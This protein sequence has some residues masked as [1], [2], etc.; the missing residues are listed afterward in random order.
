M[1]YQT[2]TSRCVALYVRG[3]ARTTEDAAALVRRALRD[4][5]LAGWPRMELDLFPS[6]GGTLILAR[7]SAGLTVAPAPWLEP[8][9]DR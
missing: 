9:L 2:V 6:G 1:D 8:Y 5:G 7:P 4:R 3:R